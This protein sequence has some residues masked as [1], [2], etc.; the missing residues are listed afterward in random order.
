LG[1]KIKLSNTIHSISSWNSPITNIPENWIQSNE[2]GIMYGK[3]RPKRAMYSAEV[4][5]L[6]DWYRNVRLRGK[7]SEESSK[8][9]SEE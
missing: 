5:E 9:S 7:T 3:R 6:A 4:V 8:E 1:R 2:V